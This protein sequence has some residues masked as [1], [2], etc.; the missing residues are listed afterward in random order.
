[1]GQY[2]SCAILYN[3]D[4]MNNVE[5][6]PSNL[7]VEQIY[8]Q[9]NEYIGKFNLKPIIQEARKRWEE[10]SPQW[11]K[12]HKFEHTDDVLKESLF[13][14]I[15]DGIKDER[16]LELLAIMATY[17]D[18][19]MTM[20][21]S[22]PDN[23]RKSH[24]KRGADFAAEEMR[25]SG[26]YTEDEIKEV[27]ESIEDTEVIMV[28]G[29]LVQRPVRHE[30]GK[31]LL[32]GDLSNLGREDFSDKSELEFTEQQLVF[33][34]PPDRPKFDGN[35]LG[36]IKNHIGQTSAWGRYRQP[37]QNLNISTLEQKIAA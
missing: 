33:A 35:T 29:V 23:L 27:S 16:K 21:P 9:V 4:P 31:Y 32:D 34:D 24:E 36:L 3:M 10:N 2:T 1:M 6:P 26:E 18:V 17:H 15:A 20:E 25:K 14:A 5:V 11:A 7:E 30:L 37:Q 12:F 22:N 13:F 28:N 19:G 8:S